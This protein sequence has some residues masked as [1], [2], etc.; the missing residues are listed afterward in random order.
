[1][2]G[3]TYEAEMAERQ[4]AEPSLPQKAVA[5]QVT[6]FLLDQPADPQAD[7]ETGCAKGTVGVDVSLPSSADSTNRSDP[8]NNLMLK[9]AAHVLESEGGSLEGV[10]NQGLLGKAMVAL[11]DF[12]PVEED[13]PRLGN[14]LYERNLVEGVTLDQMT[15]VIR[16]GEG[17][18][19]LET[20]IRERIT[21]QLEKTA[22]QFSFVNSVKLAFGRAAPAEE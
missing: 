8:R 11:Q 19:T 1:M 21:A 20:C 4:E 3:L 7:P 5:S 14:E 2:R 13:V 16:L 15:A 18:E 22:S 12:S 9:A 6:L 10:Y 17:F